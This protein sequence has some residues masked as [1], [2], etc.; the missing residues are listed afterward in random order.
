MLNNTDK[1]SIG[2]VNTYLPA[3]IDEA[4]LYD[5]ALTETQIISLAWEFD[6]DRD[7]LADV[8][9]PNP[10]N[11]DSDGDGFSDGLEM[12]AGTDLLNASSKPDITSTLKGN[13]LLNESSGTMAAD[14]TGL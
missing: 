14:S 9:D 5:C 11:P 2:R 12:L 13:W 6:S 3:R 1:I 10:E 4:G 7:H 8:D